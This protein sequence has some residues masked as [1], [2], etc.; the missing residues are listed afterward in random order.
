MENRKVCPFRVARTATLS[1]KQ[2]GVAASEF[3]R[4]QHDVARDQVVA[5]QAVELADGGGGHLGSAG[6]DLTD[7]KGSECGMGTVGTLTVPTSVIVS[8]VW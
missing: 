3:V 1:S 2:S 7:R 5:E 4:H 8:Q 6:V